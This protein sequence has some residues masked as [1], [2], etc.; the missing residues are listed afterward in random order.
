MQSSDDT[1]D[2]EYKDKVAQMKSKNDKRFAQKLLQMK[3]VIQ[4]SDFETN[5]KTLKKWNGDVQKALNELFASY[6]Q[7]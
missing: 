2:Q 4:N 1:S 5:L 7:L 3:N 6:Q